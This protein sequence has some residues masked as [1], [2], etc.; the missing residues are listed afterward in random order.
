[1]KVWMH[2]AAEVY[3]CVCSGSSSGQE[4]SDAGPLALD[5]RFIALIVAL[6]MAAALSLIL[7]GFLIVQR[8]RCKLRQANDAL[9]YLL[10]LI[11]GAR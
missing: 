11:L 2:A 1:M 4:R 9:C 7:A 5:S 10:C 3:F 6:V 8:H